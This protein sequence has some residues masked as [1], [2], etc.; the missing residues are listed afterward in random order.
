MLQICSKEH[1]FI[2]NHEMLT[3]QLEAKLVLPQQETLVSLHNFLH[4]DRQE[5]FLYNGSH[6]QNQTTQKHISQKMYCFPV[7]LNS[8]H[9]SDDL[10]IWGQWT[11]AETPKENSRFEF[12]ILTGQTLTSLQSCSSHPCN[13][14][15]VGVVQ[16]WCLQNNLIS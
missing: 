5:L 14:W 6:S 9:V 13:C 3:G 1:R 15:H 2:Q 4:V 12:T 7:F 10:V 16:T 8:S 11:L